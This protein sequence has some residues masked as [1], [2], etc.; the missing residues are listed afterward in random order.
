M[1]KDMKRIA[2]PSVT[3]DATE[4]LLRKMYISN[5]AKRLR[6]LNQPSDVDRKRWV[7]EL[8]Q[9]AKD[10]IVGDASKSEIN[11][12]IDIDGDIV[13]FRH[14][15]SPFTA[16]ARFGLLYKY[17]EDKE[18]QESTGRFGTGF[19]T[20][21]CLSKVVTIESNM[22][23]NEDR[24][25]ICGFSVT[26]Y[27]DGQ[28]E[29]ELLEG[30]DKMQES[31]EYYEETFPWTTFTYH[32]ST[33]S[34]RRAIK[35]G[36]D[37]FHENIAQTMLF[38]KELASIE[39]NY[40]GKIT[41]IV[42][43]PIVEVAPDVMSAEF[44]IC[45]EQTLTRRFLYSSFCEYNKELS[46]RYR[47]DRKIRIN[48]AIEVDS[49]NNI[50]NHSGNTSHFC[51]LPLVG[52]ESQLDEPLILNSPDFEPD[53][54]RQ[55]LLLA[56]Q[57]WDEEHNNISEV[58][59]NQTIYSKV[60]KLY[61]NLVAYL[62]TNHFGKLYLLANGLK[63]AKDHEKL[64]AKWYS[65]NVI[66]NYRDI[67]LKYAVV[68]PY[69]TVDYK[70]LSDCIIVKE[71]K[72][73]NETAVY[74][75]LSTLYSDKLVKDNHE[76][77]QYIWKEGLNS[78]DTEDLCKNIEEKKNWSN[79]VL[80]GITVT[81]W[82]NKFLTHV[83]SYDERYLKEYTLLPNM[84]GDFMKKDA[85]NFKQG[86]KVTAFIIDLLLKLGKDVKP[87]LLHDSITAITL[88]SK[89]NS[90]SYSADI[91][92][93]AKAIVDDVSPINKLQNILPLLSVL[94]S[95]VEKYNS[96]FISQRKDFF[97]IA[98]ALFSLTDAVPTEDNN[99]LSSAWSELDTWFVTYV[100]Q[101]L[102]NLGNLD[103]L[104]EG[105]D[106]KWLNDALKSLKV[107]ISSLNTYEVLPNQNG[108]FCAQNKLYEDNGVPESLKVTEFEGISLTYKNILLHKDI[109]ASS[110]AII[111]KKDIAT[112]A[113]EIK[114]KYVSQSS[115]YS[116]YPHLFNGRYFK[117]PKAS[118]DKVALYLLS[119]IPAD[120]E[121]EVGKNQ[122]SLYATASSILGSEL[123]PCCDLINYAS[124]DLWQ[125]ANFFV[126]SM[127][128]EKIKTAVNIETLNEQLGFK[129]ERYIFEQLNNF[130][131]FLQISG[132]S[133][134]VPKIFPNQEGQF[135]SISN[136][137]KEE[138]QI[139]DIIKNIICLLVNEEEDYRHI[140]MDARCSLQ[141]QASLNSDN[142]YALI[143]EKVAEFYKNPEKW[144]DVNFI[145]ASQLLIEDW[146]D[147]HKGTF[148]EKFPR[149]FDDKEK[150]LMNVVWKKEKRELMMTVSNKLTETQ[151]KFLIENSTEIQSLSETNQKLSDENEELRKQNAE[152]QRKLGIEDK[153]AVEDENE[154]LKKKLE[155]AGIDNPIPEP[156][157][158]NVYTSSGNQSLVVR[159]RQ[160]AGLSLDEIVAYVSEAKMDVVN[161]FRELNEREELGLTFDPERIALDSFSQLYG[162]YD[163]NGNELPLVV[164]SYKGPQYRYFDLNW[165]DWQLLSKTGSMLWVKT[166]TGLQCIPLY[167]L[168]I[169]NFDI[170]IGNNLP[171]VDKAKL[172]T[173][174]TT[175]KEYAYI[176]F[177]FGNNMP[178][179]FN[180]HVAFN[181]M[182][183]ELN[184]CI[185]SIKN[186]CD[187]SA[188][189]LTRLYNLGA[190]IPLTENSGNAYSLALQSADTNGT[191]RDM[192]DLPANDLQ[193]PVRG[194][195][196]ED[197]L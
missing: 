8:I 109:E 101:S 146:G 168:P 78:W 179:N 115:Y 69:Q 34:G 92:K 185:G 182:P 105:L 108:K 151:L 90:Q 20:T 99:L 147:K 18:N 98:T 66:K 82:Y 158:V 160:Y 56:G 131:D 104:P 133:Y 145:E 48:A 167:A 95:D 4:K 155:E 189:A 7:W 132:I 67:L 13:K 21:H 107:K 22:Y 153:R 32:V 122:D 111:Q 29:K 19:L 73:E 197:I 76:W 157:K 85:D 94:P 68:E 137:K 187:I 120:K 126:V 96:E 43:K 77:A 50:V 81:D 97:N 52:I 192:H 86:E 79:I 59:I 17:S 138:G 93:L 100:L 83:S 58:G 63:K 51:V 113:S 149:V 88:D 184:E 116:D 114:G 129:G 112:F 140:L 89:Y 152:L 62:S 33:E 128:S 74:G 156:V 117:Y 9:N 72:V 110:F 154:I 173:L 159:E 134:S 14:D 41:S 171:Q 162:I 141:P 11:V 60:F 49:N 103:K 84:N 26:M 181:Y 121:S 30:L 130:Y 1:E 161:Y 23:T 3:K 75:L 175:C 170:S 64:D 40:N 65:D 124:K 186:I 47:A 6:Q 27:R 150:I 38:C 39:L 2:P 28:I 12:R 164:H 136:L 135:C 44:E 119:L 144:K 127:I 106:A 180:E 54:E 55:S 71:A 25:S 143:D 172:L 15:G 123:V 102:K 24:T 165:Y 169:R 194:A 35:L 57:N 37:N 36:I 191:M 174:A 45:G 125:D 139:D 188:P 176:G 10:T 193:P 163:H 190:N 177:E 16:D 80:E 31:E 91:N 148:E 42:R 195:G 61:D 5:V 178:Q 70:K 142:A 196:L 87:T 46:D 118:L 53:E 166:V 183:T